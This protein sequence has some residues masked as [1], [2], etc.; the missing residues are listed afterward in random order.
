MHPRKLAPVVVKITEGFHA[1]TVI[2]H[3]DGQEIYH[4]SR[5]N[6]NWSANI[7]DTFIVPLAPGLVTLTVAVPTRNVMATQELLVF[8]SLLVVIL[9]VEDQ[10]EII[11]SS[12]TYIPEAD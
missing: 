5:L 3:V 10:I 12:A 1:D 8:D 6:T 7:A 9:L 11:T 4:R 2:L